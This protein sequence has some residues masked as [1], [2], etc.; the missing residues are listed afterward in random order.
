MGLELGWELEYDRGWGLGLGFRVG[1]G[2]RLNVGIGM[3]VAVRAGLEVRVSAICVTRAIGARMHVTNT[4]T[5][6]STAMNH[7]RSPEQ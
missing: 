3:K 1:C 4:P 5:E 6:A 2:V 7:Q